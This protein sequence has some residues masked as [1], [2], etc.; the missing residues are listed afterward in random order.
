MEKHLKPKQYYRDIYDSVTIE[1]CRKIE[2]DYQE[3]LKKAGYKD[4]AKMTDEIRGVYGAYY[5]IWYFDAGERWLKKSERIREMMETDEKRDELLNST[6]SPDGVHCLACNFEMKVE[7]KTLDISIKEGD[8]DRVLFI[9]RCSNNECRNGRGFYDNGEECQRKS[10]LCKKC[11]EDYVVENIRLKN[12]IKTKYSCSACGYKEADVFDLDSE[13]KKKPDKYYERDQARFCFDEKQGSKYL[14]MKN[15]M[16]QISEFMKDI[17][18]REKNKDV[19]DKAAQIKKLTL[20][21]LENVLVPVFEKNKYMKFELLKPEM[22]RD[23]RVEFTI[24]DAKSGRDEYQSK[25]GLKKLIVKALTDTNWRLMSS[26]IYYK[27]GILSG[28][29]R[30]HE[31][32][33]DLINLINSKK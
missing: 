6:E 22:G 4:G 2:K 5:Y 17:E 21:E 32:E 8:Q 19:I 1:S 30:G 26:G 12:K 31:R 7:M 11:G 15:N 14:D 24:R 13:K 27:L 28:G 16:E 23:V 20:V 29:L 25:T 33:E 3:A 9:F 18:K 10:D